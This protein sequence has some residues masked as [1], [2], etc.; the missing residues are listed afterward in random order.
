MRRR[1]F[2]AS[3]TALAGTT[4][5]QS[6]RSRLRVLVITGQTDLPYHD[7]TKTTPFLRRVLESTGRFEVTVLDDPKTLSPSLLAPYQAVILNYNGPRWGAGPEKALED[8]GRLVVQDFAD[9]CIVD[10]FKS[11][12]RPRRIRATV[13]DAR[14][15]GIA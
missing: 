1:T 10:L 13:A 5:V 12:E 3:L 11:E 15:E 2:L 7:W 8:L 6:E 4:A 14:H 9:L